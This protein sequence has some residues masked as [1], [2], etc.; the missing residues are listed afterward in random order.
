MKNRVKSKKAQQLFG[1]PFTVIF[2]IF[3]IAIFLAV[4]IYVIMHFWGIKQC[5]EIGL[6][7]NDF[8]EEVDSAWKAASYD[9]GDKPFTSVLPDKIKYVC[10]ADVKKPATGNSAEKEIFEK[11]KENVDDD[12]DNLYFYPFL[13][14]VKSTKILHVDMESLTNPYCIPVVNGKIS[15]NLKKDYFDSLVKVSK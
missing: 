5:A 11:I 14:D 3:L 10:F 12:K 4:A 8:Q 15:I 13:C 1:M 2:S 6:F 7:T 9:S